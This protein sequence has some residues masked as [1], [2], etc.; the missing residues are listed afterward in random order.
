MSQ[1]VP[2]PPQERGKQDYAEPGLGQ[3]APTQLFFVV[4]FLLF[5]P[6]MNGSQT[7]GPQPR[8]PRSAAHSGPPTPGRCGQEASL[9]TQQRG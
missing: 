6:G 8:A 9:I 7:Q 5:S 1:Q 2:K 4:F 3:T